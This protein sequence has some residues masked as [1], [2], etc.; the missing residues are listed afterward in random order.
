MD[1]CFPFGAKN[2]HN[3]LG[4]TVD[5]LI[6]ILKAAKIGPIPKWADDLFPIRFPISSTSLQDG[7][8]SY[9]YHYDLVTLKNVVAP[10]AFL[11]IQQ[12]GRNFLL[13]LFISASSGI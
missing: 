10:S 8:F 13:H 9:H 2:A 6:D 5:A 1:H 3:R 4:I 7:S 12:S 11:G